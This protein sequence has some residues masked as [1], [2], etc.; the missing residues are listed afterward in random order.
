MR[1]QI[2]IEKINL[3]INENAENFVL[4]C[5]NNYKNQI[6]NV[7]SELK[8]N[9]NIKF[10]MIAGPS[11]SG[12]TTTSKILKEMLETENINALALSLD[13][14]FL[15]RIETPLWPDGSLNFETAESI[16]WELFGTCTKALLNGDQATLPTYNFVTGSK[17]FKQSV[18]IPKDTIVIV[19]G[20]HALNPI[21]DKFIPKKNSL[22][23]YIS[24]RTNITLNGEIYISHKD[25][26]LYRRMIRDLYTRATSIDD[27]LEMWEKVR[28]G[29]KLYID[30]FVD[31]ADLSINTFH[32]YE[33][34]VYKTMFENIK[35]QS[36]SIME[37]LNTLAPFEPLSENIVP[38][39]SVLKEFTSKN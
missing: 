36:S 3:Q 22:K 6:N 15:E 30:P 18:K 10:I 27:T 13:D 17:E 32:A 2:S 4:E 23:V 38:K 5:E 25:V 34:N 39:T 14:Y 8:T 1:E 28:L 37:I 26:R 19:E 20:L 12:K 7:V 29:E 31:S 11:S 24:A 21:I 16:D 35:N 33:M 9:N